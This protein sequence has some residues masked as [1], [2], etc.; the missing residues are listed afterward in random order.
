MERILSNDVV[1]LEIQGDFLT[2]K[3]LVPMIDLE[4]AKSAL[5]LRL[6]IL[7]GE[8]K[9][10]LFDSS[11]LTRID[12]KARKYLSQP[13]AY[14]GLKASAFIIKSPVG[15]VLGNFYLRFGNFPIPTKLFRTEE[16][17]REWLLSLNL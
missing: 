6:E 1:T 12:V 17:A 2:G 15:A 7:K 8:E 5:A 9:L 4:V 3:Y 14:Q 16:V 11:N 10:L 13:L